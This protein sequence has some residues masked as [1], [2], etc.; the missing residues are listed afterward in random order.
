MM[1]QGTDT[2]DSDARLI[3]SFFNQDAPQVNTLREKAVHLANCILLANYDTEKR[4]TYALDQIKADWNI[5]LL[6]STGTLDVFNKVKQYSAGLAQPLTDLY[7]T[8]EIIEKVCERVLFDA[9]M[10][11]AVV[12]NFC[13]NPLFSHSEFRQKKPIE[14]R[15]VSAATA[16]MFVFAGFIRMKNTYS[17]QYANNLKNVGFQRLL[18]LNLKVVEW[19]NEIKAIII[20]SFT[21]TKDIYYQEGNHIIHWTRWKN[22]G[23]RESS[24]TEDHFYQLDS[25]KKACR[26]DQEYYE[27]LYN[28]CSY[29]IQGTS[30]YAYH[31]LKVIENTNLIVHTKTTV[32]SMG[33][34]LGS[35]PKLDATVNVMQ[36]HLARAKLFCVENCELLKKFNLPA[37]HR[38]CI[39]NEIEDITGS[40]LQG[41]R[42]MEKTYNQKYSRKQDHPGLQ[43]LKALAADLQWANACQF[44]E[45]EGNV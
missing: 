36:Q 31:Q 5:Q 14:Q 12:E 8:M 28:L 13:L 33:S 35:L 19:G 29:D 44:E 23:D 15:F 9:K 25:F 30:D 22:Q 11:A 10:A 16:A 4:E 37:E 3:E 21:E 34:L 38:R 6:V 40:V 26:E 43:E 24:G 41:L 1:I 2:T 39:Q 32:W 18:A 45:D 20:K 42:R 17:H 27:S 7:K